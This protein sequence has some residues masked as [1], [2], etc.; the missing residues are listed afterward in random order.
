M[1]IVTGAGVVGAGG[2]DTGVVGAGVVG[3]GVV[4]AGVV[5]A[6]VAGAGATGA[7]VCIPPPPP[8]PPQADK[9]R[10]NAATAAARCNVIRI[11]QPVFYGTLDNRSAKRPVSRAANA[12]F[13][14]RNAFSTIGYRS[15]SG[16]G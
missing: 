14:I 3:A 7:A 13:R 9:E 8:P 2:V 15:A 4:G 16:A 10:L 11:P 12:A 6:G 1:L 5:G